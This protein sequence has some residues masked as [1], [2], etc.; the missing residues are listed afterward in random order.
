[1]NY[2]KPIPIIVLLLLSFFSGYGQSPVLQA[3]VE[4][5]L[6][7]NL[8]LKQE[9]LSYERSLEDLKIAHALFLPSVTASSS[10]TWSNGGRKINFPVGDLLNPVYSTL[11]QLTSS[12]NFP[13]IE[14]VNIQFLP[15]DFHDT[16]VRVIQPLF[17]S[18]IYY[19]YKAQKELISVK[20]AQRKAYENEL[21]FAIASAYYQYLESHQAVKIFKE[22]ST[23]LQA[24]YKVNQA[25]V[26]NDKATADV[27]SSASVEVSKVDKEI[28]NAARNYQS[29]KAYFNF[30]LNREADAEIQLDSTLLSAGIK[31]YELGELTNQAIVNRQEIQQ[32]KGGMSATGYL[33]NLS[34]SNA[35]LPNLSVVGDLGAQ[36]N[37]YKF[38]S[39]QRYWLVQFNLTWDIFTGGKKQ[40][41]TQQAKIDYQLADTRY[42]QLKK[43]IELQ[44]I[45]A[46]YDLESAQKS[47]EASQSAV[48]N[49]ERSF[50]I[51]SAKYKE[52]QAILL[53]YLQAQNNWTNAKLSQ[54][55][56]TFELLRKESE[57]QKTIAIL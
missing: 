42:Q 43:Q 1:M 8:Q 53:E 7:N 45:Q 12:K 26:M 14:N 11:N 25:L 10:Y 35:A 2:S 46:Y 15:N 27:V 48:I 4:E 17:N 6:K 9:V 33:V 22:T 50:K 5:G 16:K 31:K 40:A 32:A 23:V 34:K 28:A 36:G 49:S 20:Q 44:V 24:L 29:A 13:Q 19:N 57:L 41:K 3:Y 39:D 51:I 55:I 21:K 56:S 47:F 38:N 52:G 30:L 18:D 54:S 37:E